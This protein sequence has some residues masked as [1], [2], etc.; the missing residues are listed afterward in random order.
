[1]TLKG[2][3]KLSEVFAA[4]ESQTGNRIVDFR[5][6]FN[7]EKTDPVLELDLAKAT[8][9]EALDQVLNHLTERL[10]V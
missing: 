8:F 3:R 6:N 10:L 5:G 1:M 7:Q 9:W 4:F 2:E